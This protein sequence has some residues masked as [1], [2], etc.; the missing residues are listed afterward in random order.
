MSLRYEQYRALKEARNFLRELADTEKD[1]PAGSLR[2]RAV[3]C[4][5]HFP[6]LKSTGEPMLSKDNFEPPNNERSK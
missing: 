6:F 5:R 2:H 1:M 4:L 3:R